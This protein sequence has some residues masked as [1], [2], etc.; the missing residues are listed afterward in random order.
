MKQSTTL[1]AVEV[2]EKLLGILDEMT[3]DWDMD[4]SGA[5]DDE[6]LLA[7]DLGFESIDFVML[8]SEIEGAFKKQGLPYEKLLMEDGDYV[9]DL[10]VGQVVGFLVNY[11]GTGGQGIG[12]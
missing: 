12:D 11:L 9:D 5:I 1:V 8:V 6:T 4:F 3:S 7:G 2:R 10:S